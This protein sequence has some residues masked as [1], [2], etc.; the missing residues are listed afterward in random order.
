[1]TKLLYENRGNSKSISM[2]PILLPATAGSSY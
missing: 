2:I 1:M